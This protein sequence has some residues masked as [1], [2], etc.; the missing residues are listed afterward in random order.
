MIVSAGAKNTSMRVRTLYPFSSAGLML[1]N[2]SL[3]SYKWH[4]CMLLDTKGCTRKVEF[5]LLR[6]ENQMF[7]RYNAD[8]T[9]FLVQS[10]DGKP[11]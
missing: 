9:E 2:L 10:P 8:P 3:T 1:G 4:V 6:G 5:W 7:Y 11:S